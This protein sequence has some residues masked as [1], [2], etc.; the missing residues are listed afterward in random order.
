M[1]SGSKVASGYTMLFDDTPVDKLYRVQIRDDTNTVEVTC[2]G[3]DRVDAEAE[4]IYACVD[5]LPK[6]LQERL[7]VLMV[8]DWRPPTVSV[9][10][11]GRR[12]D[13]TTYWVVCPS[14]VC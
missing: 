9:D 11:V 5:D 14:L 2:I 3:I 8:L 1:V 10:N 13:K 6:W 4:G 7:S 12:I